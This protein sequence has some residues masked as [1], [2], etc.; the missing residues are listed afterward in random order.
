MIPD[1]KDTPALAGTSRGG[2]VGS[3]TRTWLTTKEA[4]EA[5]GLTPETIRSQIWLGH[6]QAHL[7]HPRK[8]LISL[9]E[10]E[11]YRQEHLGRFRWHK[12]RAPGYT[13]S[14]QAERSRRYHARKK[15]AQQHHTEEQ[16]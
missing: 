2:T 14:K 5:L 4:A 13:P 15:A 9:T 1:D 16:P 10:V 8:A 11:R 6:L 12:R 7:D 3:D